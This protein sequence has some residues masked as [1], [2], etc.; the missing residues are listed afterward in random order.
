MA[1]TAQDAASWSNFWQAQI[2]DAFVA[3][4]HQED[5]LQALWSEV[6]LEWR[7]GD[8]VLDIGCGNGALSRTLGTFAD[9]EQRPFS[10]VGI[11]RAKISGDIEHAF[12]FLTT[13]L[14]G[15]I[16]VEEKYFPKASF[17]RVVSQF[18]FEYCEMGSVIEN[19]WEWIAE[20]GSFA[21]LLHSSDSALSAEVR[22]TLEQMR[23]AEE[24]A[25]L[26]A[27]ARLLDRLDRVGQGA[28]S[29]PMSEEL[30]ELINDICQELD[31][32]SADMPN[33]YFLK[34]FVSLCLGFFDEQR[35]RLSGSIRLSSLGR[36]SQHLVHHKT[37]L[38]Q[39]RRV[40]LDPAGIARLIEQF[41]AQGFSCSKTESFRFDQ[42]TIGFFLVGE[43]V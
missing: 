31:R 21:L 23:M 4:E 10:Y 38:D 6:F 2:E 34:S 19:M 15:D 42:M 41:T 12:E 9:S 37:R 8:R 3:S 5:A 28:N 17:D 1:N 40:A 35:A 32:K 30:R 22:Y 36:L 43:R 29:D 7:A 24:S 26:V 16:P 20:G 14:I 33:P 18:G 25:L 13:E 27:V 39:Q 11:D